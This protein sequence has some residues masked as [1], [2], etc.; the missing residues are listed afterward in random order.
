MSWRSILN[1]INILGIVITA[2]S[3]FMIFPI[4]VSLIYKQSDTLYLVKSLLIT[5]AAGSILYFLTRGYKKKELGHKEA[6]VA[7]TASWVAMAFFGSIPYMLSGTFHSFTDAYF[8]SMAGFTTTGATVLADIEAMPKGILFW[9]CMTQ[10]IGGMGIILLALAILPMLGGGG[11][12]LFRAEF[13]EIGVDKLRPRIINTAKALW[14][15]YVGLTSFAAVSYMIGGMSFYDAICHAFTTI[16]IGGFST[17]NASIAYFES[18]SIEYTAIFFMLLA[19][20]NY[21]FYFYLLRGNISRLWRSNE[22]KF[23]LT[24]IAIAA[25]LVIV[26]TWKTSYESISDAIRY[27]LFQVVSLMTTTGYTTA[28]YETWSPFA[29]IVLIIAMFFGGMIGSTCGGIKQVRILLV[30]KQAYREIYQLI[31][32]R[33]VTLIK[34]NDKVVAKGTLRSIWGFLFLFTFVGVAATISMAAIG[35]DIITSSTTVISALCNVGPAFGDAGPTDRHIH[36][37][38]AGKWVLIFC[39][40]TGRLEVYTVLILF[41]PHFWKK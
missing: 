9:R 40:L 35:T 26:A 11:M 3:L 37:P 14:I 32:P 18:P 21:S 38:G 13:P 17:K 15:I 2:I 8:E 33:A 6:F 29:Q 34:L 41:V 30:F 12:Q 39:M 7:V 28:D 5:L 25:A 36:L 23:Y 19:G 22:F 4:A 27:S 1:I 31:H 24:T 16:A 20:I 10:W